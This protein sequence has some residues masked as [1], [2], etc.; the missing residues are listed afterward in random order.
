MAGPVVD[1]DPLFGS[2]G[3]RAWIRFCRKDRAQSTE[4]PPFRVSRPSIILN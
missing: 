1:F 2:L 4:L 3:L